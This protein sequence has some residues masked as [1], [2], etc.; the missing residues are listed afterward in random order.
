MYAYD[1]NLH[2]DF[3]IQVGDCLLQLEELSLPITHNA[4]LRLWG[5]MRGWKSLRALKPSGGTGDLE[6]FEGT[7]PCL[8]SLTPIRC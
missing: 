2:V 5:D 8:R 4:E 6:A 3:N 7:V 1:P